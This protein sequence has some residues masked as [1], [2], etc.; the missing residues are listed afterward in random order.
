[1]DQYM[2]KYAVDYWEDDEKKTDKGVVVAENLIKA[3]ERL[4]RYYGDGI[5][6]VSIGDS[7]LEFTNW[8][9]IIRKN[10]IDELMKALED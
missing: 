10:E 7:P 8:D 6:F 3:V 9:G 4:D 5:S 1:M 2:F